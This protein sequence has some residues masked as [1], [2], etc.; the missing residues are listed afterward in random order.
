MYSINK[1]EYGIG[2]YYKFNNSLAVAEASIMAKNYGGRD[3]LYFNR[4]HVPDN[5]TNSG[6]GSKLLD[7]LLKE[8]KDAN[9]ILLCTINPYGRLNYDSLKRWY[10]RHGFKVQ[11]EHGN[12]VVLIYND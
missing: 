5:L 12:E 8:V 4:I 10:I 6:I 11:E 7:M 9:L 1:S 2:V 3:V